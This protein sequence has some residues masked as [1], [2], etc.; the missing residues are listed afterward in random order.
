MPTRSMRLKEVSLSRKQSAVTR[1]RPGWVG[2]HGGGG[3][4]GQAVGVQ[5]GGDGANVPQAGEY[6]G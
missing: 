6:T 3:T 5:L 4:E 1:R 2:V